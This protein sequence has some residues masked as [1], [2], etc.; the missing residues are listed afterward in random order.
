[1]KLIT[2]LTT[3]IITLA[4][5]NVF[6]KTFVCE[7]WVS[8]IEDEDL[9]SHGTMF[10]GSK[11]GLNLIIKN[12]NKSKI[13]LTYIGSDPG[14]GEYYKTNFDSEYISIYAIHSNTINVPKLRDN[15]QILVTYDFM[16]SWVTAFGVMY[17]TYCN[18]Q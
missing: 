12:H 8:K 14:W 16:L 1:M 3:L 5:S 10:T 18:Y 4:S 7:N 13:S 9:E 17:Q 15:K 2:L 11:D 6:A